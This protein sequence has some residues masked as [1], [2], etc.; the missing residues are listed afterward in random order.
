[1]C[2]V[3]RTDGE[4][5]NVTPEGSHEKKKEYLSNKFN[6]IGKQ[7]TVRFFERTITGVPFHAVGV[8][9]DYEK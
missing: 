9:R 2:L 1:M 8:V 4:R 5:F 3:S 6:Y 7:L